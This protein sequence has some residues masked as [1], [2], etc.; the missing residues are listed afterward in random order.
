MTVEYRD[1][2][3][4]YWTHVGDVRQAVVS[5]TSAL[6]VLDKPA[7]LKWAEAAGAEGAVR[8]ERDGMLTDVDPSQ[9]IDIVRINGLVRLDDLMSA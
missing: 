3:H 2:S 5:V 7:L 6:K 4:R 1:A 8:L 9:V